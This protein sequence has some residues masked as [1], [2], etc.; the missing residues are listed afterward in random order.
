MKSKRSLLIAIRSGDKVPEHFGEYWSPEDIEQLEALY[1]GGEDLSDIVL[2]FG[3][4][5]A[6]VCHQVDEL[7]RRSGQRKRRSRKKKATLPKNCPC[8]VCSVADCANCGKECSHAGA[9]R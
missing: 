6:A 9:V 7:R 5:E 1:Y 2:L 3:R 4:G 8:P